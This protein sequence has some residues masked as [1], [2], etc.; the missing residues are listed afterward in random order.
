MKLYL[1]LGLILPQLAL[2][3]Y[4]GDP[5][6]TRHGGTAIDSSSSNGIPHVSSGTWSVSSLVGADLPFPGA[7]SL[8]GV[9][10]K[11]CSASQFVTQLNTSGVL[12]CTQ[13]AFSDLSGQISTSQIPN[14]AV[15]AGS[16]TNANITVDA[17]GRIT[18]AANGSAGSVTSVTGTAPVVSSGGSTPAISMPV[19]TNS[20]DG[21]LSAA[22]HTTFAAKQAAGNYITALTGDVTASGPGS[23]AATLANTAVTPG[24]YTS[25]NITVDSKGRIT[26]AANG[27]GG[28]GS[29]TT[30]FS[31]EGAIVPFTSI[32]G[33]HYQQSTQSLTSVFLSCLNSGTSGSTVFQ[34]NQ[35]RSGSLQGSATASLSSS[36]GNPAGG[37]PSL[38]GTLS[39][40]AGD[41]I[42]VDV[43]S[44]AAGASDCSLEY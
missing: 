10:S 21:Y 33:A 32:N 1:L 35:Y 9:Q 8:G 24:S 12:A 5:Q 11:T 3:T 26:A 34:V 6:L 38:S 40:L 44:A 7:S 20:V 18:S 42:T 29:G 23:A 25:A 2:A 19:S 28:S 14:T 41:I 13:P 36:S 4:Y 37:N 15:T 39:L 43:N 30:R 17:Q 27:S 31:L 16:Y 22:D